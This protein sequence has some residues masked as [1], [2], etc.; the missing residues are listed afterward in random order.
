MP[1]HEPGQPEWFLH[2]LYDKLAARQAGMQENDD[3]YEGNHPLPFVTKTHN[4]KMRD[5]FRGMLEDS[6][7]NFM[8]LVVDVV[9]ERTRVDG[10]RVGSA[11]DPTTDA[12]AWGIW[13]ANNLDAE[14]Q[15]AFIDSLVKGVSYLSV[16]KNPGDD[17]PTIAVEDASQTIVDY[18]PGSN[19]RKRAAALKIWTDD[20]TGHERADVWMPDGIHKF[21]RSARDKEQ[22]TSDFERPK[23]WARI[24]TGDF[25]S[26]PQ[27]IVP[28]IPLRNRPRLL[29]EGTSEIDGPKP[30]QKRINSKLFLLALAGYFGAHR[31]RWAVNLALMEDDEGNPVEPFDVAVDKLWQVDPPEEPGAPEVKFGEFDATPLDGYIKA[32]EQDVLHI[33]VTTRTPRHYLIESGQAPSGDSIRSAESGL[34]KKAARKCR[35][36]G[37]DIEEAMRI[38]RGFTDAGPTPIDSEVVWAST[39]IQSE[40]E[41]TD[42]TIKQFQAGLIPYEAALEK[43]G[44]SQTE[45]RRFSAD[46]LKDRL[47]NLSNTTPEEQIPATEPAAAA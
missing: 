10:F 39:E 42:A 1:E 21:S 25:V 20:W 15:A 36:W 22:S 41:R 19:F 40:A 27:N 3:F 29:T 17:V 26:N 30:I 11:S 14:T 12:E 28:I 5:E 9:E 18:V 16:W 43:L 13:Q 8:S 24:E 7:S 35:T 47:L 31:Q 23:N 32:I 46:R 33:S 38:A 2:R 37:E 34:T 45:I 44:Y 4:A 6:N